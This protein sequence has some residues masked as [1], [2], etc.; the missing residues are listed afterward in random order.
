MFPI[1]VNKQVLLLAVSVLQIN[2][3]A[4]INPRVAVALDDLF[5]FVSLCMVAD[6]CLVLVSTNQTYA[7]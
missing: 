5:A 2:I 4:G 6:S 1:F 3:G 7:R